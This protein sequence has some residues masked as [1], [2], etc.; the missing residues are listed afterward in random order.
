MKKEEYIKITNEILNGKT[1]D[2]L[3]KL[4]LYEL[5][6]SYYIFLIPLRTISL[7]S[8]FFTRFTQV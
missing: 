3:I 1:K 4:I 2:S 5:L 6:I 7:Y 8:S